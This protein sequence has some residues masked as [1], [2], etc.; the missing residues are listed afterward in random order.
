HLRK[1]RKRGMS[2]DAGSARAVRR[3]VI[4]TVTCQDITAGHMQQ[5]VNAAPTPGES[6]RVQGMISALVAAGL[7][8][9]Y[10]A[11]P[12]LAKVHWQARGRPPPPP[13]VTGAGGIA[14][15]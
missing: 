10:L 4:D 8:G 15:W 3:P 2:H 9:G 7:E 5:I 12:Q 13:R 1:R 11:N 14:L 6:D